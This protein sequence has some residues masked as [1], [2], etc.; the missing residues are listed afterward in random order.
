MSVISIEEN[1][2]KRFYEILGEENNNFEYMTNEKYDS[3]IISLENKEL[4]LKSSSKPS[5]FYYNIKSYVLL[6]IGSDKILCRNNKDFENCKSADNGNFGINIEKI[7]R[8]CHIEEIFDLIKNAH[9]NTG[10]AAARKTHAEVSKKYSNISRELCDLYRKLC[11]C[12]C[13]RKV[14][15]RPGDYQPIISETF[16]SLGQV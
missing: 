5:N 2:R 7:R 11:T 8:V 4:I 13:E 6:N 10:H 3:I 15:G 1:H 12:N 16:N 9:L 14:T